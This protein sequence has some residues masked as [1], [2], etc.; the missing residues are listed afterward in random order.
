[1]AGLLVARQPIF[2]Q[3][4]QLSGYELLYRGPGQDGSPEEW[5]NRATS[6]VLVSLLTG[7]ELERLVGGHPVYVNLTQE[8][9]LDLP[10]LPLVPERM[11]L[12]VLEDVVVDP[13]LLASVQELARQGHTIALDDFVLQP[14]NRKLLEMADLVKVDVQA[15]GWEQLA[16]V[17]SSLRQYG[18]RLVAEKVETH[19]E[20]TFCRYLGFDL[21]QGF[22]FAHPREVSCRPLSGSSLQLVNLLGRLHDPALTLEELI[23]LVEQDVSLSYRLLRLINSSYF[24]IHREVDS[25]ARAVAYLGLNPV[26]TWVTWLAMARVED[27]PQELMI[28][29]LVRARMAAALGQ[30]MGNRPRDGYFT[31]GLFSSLDALVDRP[32]AEVVASLPISEDLSAALL[33]RDGPLGEVLG[34]VLRFERGEWEVKDALPLDSEE[35]GASYR[36]AV[37]WVEELRE[38]LV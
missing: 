30:N 26:R 21:F 25:V 34:V 4:L 36:E 1:M 20:F 31:A 24:P 22:F 10:S 23:G 9:L 19:A 2:D 35:V 27:K 13:S 12:E 32:M 28:T 18:A 6:E 17:A 29:S 15:H 37:A 7:E 5:G 38:A 16:E 11:V 3:E 33:R 8:F 14:E